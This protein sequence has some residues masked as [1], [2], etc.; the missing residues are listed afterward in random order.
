[1]NS[2]FKI[3]F[4]LARR[5]GGGGGCS[6]DFLPY[7]YCKQYFYNLLFWI[8]VYAKWNFATILDLIFAVFFLHVF[9][10]VNAFR[11]CTQLLQAFLHHWTSENVSKKRFKHFISVKKV[12]QKRK[13]KKNW[14]YQLLNWK[15]LNGISL[16]PIG[17]L[18]WRWI[19]REQA[20][21]NLKIKKKRGSSINPDIHHSKVPSSE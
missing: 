18:I 1:M 19:T 11:N 13:N 9:S 3:I 14:Y 15:P 5:R 10:G 6:C 7:K 17:Y 20:F 12:M 21:L 4:V 2:W 8:S 16:I